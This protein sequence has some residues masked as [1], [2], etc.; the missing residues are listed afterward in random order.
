MDRVDH[1]IVSKSFAAETTSQADPEEAAK[2]LHGGSGRACTAVTCGSDGC[3]YLQGRV[4]GTVRRRAT[5]VVEVIET[6]GCGDVFHG[7]YAAALARGGNVVECI[8]F[9]TA[10]AA[11]YASRPGGWQHLPRASDVQKM[12][13]Q[14]RS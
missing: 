9:A 11:V 5:P 7:A 2:R 12:L 10:A 3:F 14:V 13:E 4:D 8:R 1:L 6:T